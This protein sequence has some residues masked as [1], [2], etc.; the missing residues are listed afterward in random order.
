M[1]YLHAE[2][3]LNAGDAA[4]VTL[5][6]Q[7][8]VLLL[9]DINYSAYRRG[10]SFRYFGGLAKKSLCRV[11]A[12]HS[13]RWHVVVDMGGYGGSVRAGIAFSKN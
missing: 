3:Y 1:E 12:P 11:V 4:V 10:D 5:D 7:A 8:N 9:D 6:R 2:D 13:G